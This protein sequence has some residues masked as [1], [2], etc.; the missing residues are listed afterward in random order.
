MSGF[1]PTGVVGAFT[2]GSVSVSMTSG[3]KTIGGL[4]R[5]VLAVVVVV[6]AV[7]AVVVVVLVVVLAVDI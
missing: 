3:T 5:V 1:G 2:S 7:L 4:E 6:L